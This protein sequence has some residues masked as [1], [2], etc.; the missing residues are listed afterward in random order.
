MKVGDLIRVKANPPYMGNRAF[1]GQLGV[2]IKIAPRA[3]KIHA[4]LT[5]GSKV[6]FRTRELEVVNE[7]R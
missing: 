5:G 3:L 1:V 2:I 4:M 7:S 6:W